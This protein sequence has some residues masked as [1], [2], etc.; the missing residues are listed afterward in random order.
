[1]YVYIDEKDP[2][3]FIMKIKVKKNERLANQF[4]SSLN[5]ATDIY[6][7]MRGIHGDDHHPIPIMH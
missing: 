1:M 4:W 6:W 5:D 7:M 3:L 2:R